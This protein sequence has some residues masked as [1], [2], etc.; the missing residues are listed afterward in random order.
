MDMRDKYKLLV[1][2]A[3]ASSMLCGLGSVG[4]AWAE[5]GEEDEANSAE[6]PQV[7]NR[8]RPGKNQGPQLS[9]AELKKRREKVLAEMATNENVL[10]NVTDREMPSSPDIINLGRRGAKALAKCLSDNVTDELRIHCAG[11]LG[12]IGDTSSLPA[13]HGALEAWDASVRG[14]ALEALR[15]IPHASNV[16]PLLKIAT[17]EDEEPGNV[18]TAYRLLGATLNGKAIKFLRAEL[19]KSEDKSGDESG[20]RAGRAAYQDAAFDGLW[21]SRSVVARDAIV[22]DVEFALRSKSSSLQAK[23][24]KAA[25]ELQAARLVPVLSTL[26]TNSDV[27]VRNNAVYAL[28]KVGDKAAAAALLA[29]VP[30]VREARML[31]N[32]AFALERIDSKAF[33][34]TA[35]KLAEHKQAAIRMNTAFVLGDVK[36]SE[37]LPLLEKALL[38]KN[39]F[40]RLSAVN[41]IGKIDGAPSVKL[42]ERF[43]DDQNPNLRHEAIYGLFHA[44]GK[45]RTELIWSKMYASENPQIKLEATLALAET[46]DARVV[47]DVLTCLERRQC[48]GKTID[49]Y[50][51]ATKAP[52]VPGRV[53]L[54]WM[55]GR[56]DLASMVIALKPQG[57]APLA[58]S[59]ISKAIAHNTTASMTSAVDVSAAFK[60]KSAQAALAR[61]AA[62]EVPVVRLHGL[63]ALASLGDTAA[64][65]KIFAEL[66]NLAA[67]RLASFTEVLAEVATPEVRTR[68]LPELVKRERSPDTRL[69]LACAKVHL[70]WNVDVAIFRFIEA[71]GSTQVLERDLAYRILRSDSRPQVTALLRRALAREG[72]PYAKDALRT[73]LDARPKD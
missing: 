18:L 26:M 57:A 15:L 11:L 39:D 53:M 49:D 37:G 52:E 1:L 62:H 43:A 64:D 60:D 42:L 45:K 13:I 46:G 21:R 29:Q 7:A 5:D 31:N 38:D 4:R 72:R 35:E 30:K 10:I 54:E 44:S 66:D 59:A 48:G 51:L 22:S 25:A 33:F 6:P 24:T 41:A 28:G 32:I 63:L 9:A 12:R 34:G 23:A 20:S 67:L 40:V 3:L 71:L 69:A 73:L 68:L 36:R 16:D 19:R 65:A 61:V 55:S 17:R 27:R 70:A 14:S 2:G 56:H 50:L 47:E 58:A 8:K